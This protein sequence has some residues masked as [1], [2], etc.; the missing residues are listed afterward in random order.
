MTG[1]R[2]PVLLT[3]DDNHSMHDVYALAFERHYDHI[4]AYCGQDALK[5]V[6]AETIDVMVLDL[7]MPG[8]HG[9]DV[10][11]RALKLKPRLIVIVS[12]VINTSQSALKAI[13]LGAADYFVK[14]TDPDVMEMVVR[15]LLASRANPAIPI[16]QPSLVARR[17]LLVGLDPGFRAALTVALQPHCRVDS[18]PQI[19]TAIQMLG[20][21][22]PDLVIVD[23]RAASI[24]RALALQNLRSNF[25]EGPMIVVGSA[26]RISPLLQP[27]VG[28]CEILVPEP[29]DFGLLFGEIANL[30]RPDPFG[31]PM[32]KLGPASSA[33]VGRVVTQYPDHTLRVEH[34]SVRT[35]F[36]AT[37]FAHIFSGEMGIPPME[38][39]Q[40][41]RI[42]AAIFTLRETR[43]KVC[44]IAQRYG[45]YDG[46]HLA[47][48]LRRRGLGCPRDF[49]QA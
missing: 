23:L 47:F 43:D 11:D 3:V 27:S 35:G 2:R 24:E 33:A 41:V 21:I 13:R 34:L 36:S 7:I 9:L 8:L 18:A 39:V 5:I 38:Y 17:I 20:S 1:Q 49:R 16:P 28:H 19:S 12:S 15:Q 29:V 31:I 30:L 46:P 26:D 44:T 37:H 32:K 22:M 40:R 14:P 42:Q 4:R 6:R 25:P 48:A 10:L 45:F